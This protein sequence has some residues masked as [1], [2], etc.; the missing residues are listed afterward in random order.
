ML[1]IAAAKQNQLLSQ[2]L[3]YLTMPSRSH[4][5]LNSFHLIDNLL[6]W[7]MKSCE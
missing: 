6:S 7:G 2:H 1:S 4:N 3:L 5:D